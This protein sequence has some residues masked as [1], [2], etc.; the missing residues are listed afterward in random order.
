MM[1]YM[2]FRFR[3][4]ERVSYGINVEVLFQKGMLSFKF[5]TLLTDNVRL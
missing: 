3:F 2:G 1:T 4:T 5:F